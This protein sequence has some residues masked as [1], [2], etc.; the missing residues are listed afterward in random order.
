MMYGIF[1]G[2]LFFAVWVVAEDIYYKITAFTDEEGQ[3][4]QS[5]H[6]TSETVDGRTVINI[7]LRDVTSPDVNRYI[8]WLAKQKLNAYK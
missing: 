6:S 7:N 8:R 5:A 4:F 3:A 2:L 1:A